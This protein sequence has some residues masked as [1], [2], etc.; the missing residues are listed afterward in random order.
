MEYAIGFLKN[1]RFLGFLKNLEYAM[2]LERSGVGSANCL[3]SSV[4]SDS[5]VLA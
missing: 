3:A 2:G 4:L 1:P 5:G